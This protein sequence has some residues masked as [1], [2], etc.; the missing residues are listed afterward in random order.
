MKSSRPPLVL[1]AVGKARQAAIAFVMSLTVQTAFARDPDI[2]TAGFEGTNYGA[3]A[4]F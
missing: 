3:W 1:A 4:V 2:V